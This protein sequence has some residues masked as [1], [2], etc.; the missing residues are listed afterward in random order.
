MGDYRHGGPEVELYCDMGSNITIITP[1]MYKKSMGK[2]VAARSHLR[3]WGSNKYLDT[4]GM[5][6]TTLNTSSSATKETWVYMMA[7]ARPE[8]LLGDHN[9]E[10]LGV[11]SFHPKSAQEN[12]LGLLSHLGCGIKTPLSLR[13]QLTLTLTCPVTGVAKARH[14]LNSVQN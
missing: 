4:K 10:D 5:F 11:I 1:D 14:F 6:K 9:A 2:V 12:K 3:A 7:G 8:P 13:E